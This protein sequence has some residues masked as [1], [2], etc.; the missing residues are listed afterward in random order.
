MAYLDNLLATTFS[1]IV[2][3]SEADQRAYLAQIAAKPDA[4]QRDG[5][6]R[7][8]EAALADPAYDWDALFDRH[9][10]GCAV[11]DDP[12][13]FVVK[14]IWAPLFA[15]ASVPGSV[16][17]ASAPEPASRHQGGAPTRSGRRARSA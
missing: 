1:A 8:L 6:R 10:V 14:R 7:E 17:W 16:A 13:R 11:D 3:E 2:A 15:P 5:L 9:D 12:R 4:R